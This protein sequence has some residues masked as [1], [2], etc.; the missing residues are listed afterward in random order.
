MEN[1]VVKAMNGNSVAYLGECKVYEY[2]LIREMFPDVYA[3]GVDEEGDL[4]LVC[5]PDLGDE[6]IGELQNDL[7]EFDYEYEVFTRE[8]SAKFA[9]AIEKANENLQ[10]GIYSAE[11]FNKAYSEAIAE[12]S[13]EYKP[14][15]ESA[16]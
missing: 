8:R 12:W 13:V 10:R 1:N 4:I 2:N 6:F 15:S 16:A 7:G 9:K 5:S 3:D 11:D 14:K